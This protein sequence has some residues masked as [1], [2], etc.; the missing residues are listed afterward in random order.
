M[1]NFEINSKRTDSMTWQHS[2]K[3]NRTNLSKFKNFELLMIDSSLE[4][5]EKQKYVVEKFLASSLFELFDFEVR[6]ST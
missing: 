3:Y 4:S 1:H 5:T 6:I 2:K